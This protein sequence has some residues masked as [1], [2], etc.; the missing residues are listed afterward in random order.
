MMW[1]SPLGLRL[2]Y[3]I[4]SPMEIPT[5]WLWRDLAAEGKFAMLTPPVATHDDEAHDTLLRGKIFDTV[6]VLPCHYRSLQ[7]RPDDVVV[8]R[9]GAAG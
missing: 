5:D 1:Y 4:L 2:A 6:A 8:L 3:D 7:E 9:G